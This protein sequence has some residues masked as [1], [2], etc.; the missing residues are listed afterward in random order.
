MGFKIMSVD[1]TLP[2]MAFQFILTAATNHDTYEREVY[3]FN[4]VL[5]DVGGLFTAMKMIG[6]IVNSYF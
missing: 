6:M 2:N 5:S 3:A 1:T 4:N